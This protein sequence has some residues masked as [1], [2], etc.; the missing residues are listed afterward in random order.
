MKKKILIIALIFSFLLL[1]AFLILAQEVPLPPNPD[2]TKTPTSPPTT[3]TTIDSANPT[4]WTQEYLTNLND[5][6]I[7][8][9]LFPEGAKPDFTQAVNKK[10]SELFSKLPDSFKQTFV[11]KTLNL[12]KDALKEMKFD[13][14][15]MTGK[16]DKYAL[17]DKKGRKLPLEQTKHKSTEEQIADN[18]KPGAIPSNILVDTSIMRNLKG[19]SYFEQYGFRYE[20]NSEDKKDNHV[21]TDQG[22]LDKNGLVQGLKGFEER[23]IDITF[24]KVV[25]EGDGKG[26]PENSGGKIVQFGRATE[27]KDNPDKWGTGIHVWGKGVFFGIQDKEGKSLQLFRVSPKDENFAGQS[28]VG[29]GH[30]SLI[31]LQSQIFRTRGDFIDLKTKT[32]TTIPTNNGLVILSDKKDLPEGYKDYKQANIFFNI[33]ADKKPFLDISGTLENGAIVIPKESEP[34]ALIK[35]PVES[36]KNLVFYKKDEKTGN[37]DEK[38]FYAIKDGKEL[39]PRTNS[40]VTTQSQEGKT[41]TQNSQVQPPTDEAGSVPPTTT[42]ETPTPNP[43]ATTPGTTTPETPKTPETPTTPPDTTKPETP[44]V[45]TTN[46]DGTKISQGASSIFE[47]IGNVLIRNILPPAKPG[48]NVAPPE[49]TT[50]PVK[51]PPKTTD[52]SND[53]PIPEDTK[54]EVKPPVKKQPPIKTN[55]DG[56]NPPTIAPPASTPINM[57]KSAKWQVN[58]TSENPYY[59]FY[60]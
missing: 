53:I 28:Y 16:D 39:V 59:I 30:L 52:E 38:P 3:A 21:Y 47:D 9:T 44:K 22:Y 58:P 31:D 32:Q 25:L 13:N 48:E 14:L 42:P 29:Y 2:G 49:V 46:L 51:E 45:P 34:S 12:P 36:G 33:D 57:D 11:S 55:N 19:I 26:K 7:I 23:P 15:E 24:P 5:E 60:S 37:V 17:T 41:V 18:K 43:P 10:V 35:F 20:F 54:T 40:G 8:K 56:S 27:E 6:D 50:P 1:N 4:T